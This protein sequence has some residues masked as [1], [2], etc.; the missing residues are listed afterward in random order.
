ML[1]KTS[2]S[3][4]NTPVGSVKQGTTP[5]NSNLTITKQ[6]VAPASA[7]AGSV[8]QKPNLANNT[9]VRPLAAGDGNRLVPTLLDYAGE[10]SASSQSKSLAEKVVKEMTGNSNNSNGASS[11]GLSILASSAA[12]QKYMSDR[13]WDHVVSDILRQTDNKKDNS[14]LQQFQNYASTVFQQQLSKDD[15]NKIS[16][17][18]SQVSPSSQQSSLQLKPQDAQ[19]MVQKLKA[20]QMPKQTPP[21]AH[22]KQITQNQLAAFL[23][24]K[25]V[26]SA[27]SPQ[28]AF[29][30]FL[31][32]R[33]KQ[34][35]PSQVSGDAKAKVVTA[36]PVQK[37]KTI[38]VQR[39]SE[40]NN[41]SHGNINVHKFSPPN[42]SSASTD[43]S[44]KP[45]LVR[46]ISQGSGSMMTSNQ[47]QGQKISP[48]SNI[49]VQ[50]VSPQQASPGI[51][52]HSPSKSSAHYQTS[53]LNTSKGE[54][55]ATNLLQSL[56]GQ[57]D[58]HA[59][60]KSP[61]PSGISRSSAPQNKSS[62][63][64]IW[65]MTSIVQSQT[66][67]VPA[68][69]SPTYAMP[70]LPKPVPGY[71]SIKPLSL[72]RDAAAGIGISSQSSSTMKSLLHTNIPQGKTLC[73]LLY[74]SK[75]TNFEFKFE[76]I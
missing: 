49:S 51:Q 32:N 30:Q 47:V 54:T 6:G 13:S 3:T 23:S 75:N 55:T 31:E 70:G 57:I 11:L 12:S 28:D 74:M 29:K 59:R 8:S 52:R 64:P 21:Q 63:S 10:Q 50:R 9:P 19:S 14:Y 22:Q 41:S 44:K 76:N 20:A 43:V 72:G 17:T 40:S 58:Q 35:P 34:F 36:R 66:G 73:L 69:T 68:K 4:A 24:Q 27:S 5:Q 39:N 62:A 48:T 67:S 26:G 38:I 65:S 37:V 7:P 45:P 53:L 46:S 33:D 42:L 60:Q 16:P 71:Q 18:K 15:G 25:G 1:T 56:F 61:S 2:N